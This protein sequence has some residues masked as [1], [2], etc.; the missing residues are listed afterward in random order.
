MKH[1]YWHKISNFV[2]EKN[3]GIRN[4]A[5]SHHPGRLQVRATSVLHAVVVK[6]VIT[7]PQNILRLHVG[8][9]ACTPQGTVAVPPIADGAEP[10]NQL[11]IC[12]ERVGQVLLLYPG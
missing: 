12:R 11:D 10:A 9:L 8:T 1:S 3:P 4:I 6:V 5:R 7:G 2:G